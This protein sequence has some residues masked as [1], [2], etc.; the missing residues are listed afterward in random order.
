M[1]ARD[2]DDGLFRVAFASGSQGHEVDLA[3]IIEPLTAFITADSNRRLL[4]IGHFDQKHLPEAL[5]DQVESVSFST[6]PKY[7]AAL[8]RADCAV[9]PLSDDIFNQCKSAVR[10]IDAASV[11]VPSIVGTV[12]DLKNV[13]RDG[14]T[15]FVASDKADWA[16]ALETLGRDAA[17]AR[18]MGQAASRDLEETWVG[19]DSAHIVSSE[20]LEWVKG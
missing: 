16:T 6:Y 1:A 14:E 4:V 3:E 5:V 19:S 2:T 12:G 13:V 8:A 20:V 7:A 11:G 17:L 10:V 9:M 15:G 18:Q